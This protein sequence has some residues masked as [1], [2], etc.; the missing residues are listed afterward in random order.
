MVEEKNCL[1][2]LNNNFITTKRRTF[3]QIR[4]LILS[5]LFQKRKTINQIAKDIDVNWRTVDNH[6]THLSERELIKEVFSSE[7]VRIFDITNQ[8]RQHL[9]SITTGT[10]NQN[11]ISQQDY[12][13]SQEVEE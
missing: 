5:A 8:G 1:N 13:L 2:V 3:D 11:T 12:E 6:L 4:L 10:T 9:K 7:Y